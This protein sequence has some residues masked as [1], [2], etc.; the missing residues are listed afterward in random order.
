VAY[1]HSLVIGL[2]VLGLAIDTLIRRRP[3]PFSLRET[4]PDHEEAADTTDSFMGRSEG[5]GKRTTAADFTR[6]ARW[7]TLNR[8]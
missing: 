8:R 4:W 5:G 7:D 2:T 3:L 1:L 6:Y